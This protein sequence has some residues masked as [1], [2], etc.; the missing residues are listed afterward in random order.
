MFG[1]QRYVGDTI[2]V[3][4]SSDVHD[5]LN[6]TCDNLVSAI[7][8]FQQSGSGWILYKLVALELHFLE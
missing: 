2:E 4:D 6:S 1:Y 8:D 3:Y 7:E 5:A